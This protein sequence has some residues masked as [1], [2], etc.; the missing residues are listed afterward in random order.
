MEYSTKAIRPI[1]SIS[2][3]M[4]LIKGT[5]NSF[6]IGLTLIID[7]LS[8]QVQHQAWQFLT[9]WHTLLLNNLYKLTVSAG[10]VPLDQWFFGQMVLTFNVPL[11]FLSPVP[12]VRS[13]V[14]LVP[15]YL[16]TFVHRTITTLFLMFLVL[17]STGPLVGFQTF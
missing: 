9:H 13:I 8:M 10:P 17:C 1:K 6:V 16:I 11:I 5:N 2:I 3:T 14:L 7:V 15:C 12:I 4:Q